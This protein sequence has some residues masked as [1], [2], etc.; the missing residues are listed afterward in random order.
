MDKYTPLTNDIEAFKE[1]N[2]ELSLKIQFFDEL[3]EHSHALHY[4][5]DLKKDK[6]CYV[7]ENVTFFLGYTP[8]EIYQRSFKQLL[9]EIHPDDLEVVDSQI[10]AASL[11][12]CKKKFHYVFEYRRKTKN[13]MYNWFQDWAT[14]VLDDGGNL[15]YILGSLY[16]I[17]ERKNR[18]EKLQKINRDLEKLLAERTKQYHNKSTQFEKDSVNW[19]KAAQRSNKTE[20][21]YKTAFDSIP[22]FIM[23]I[24]S[25]SLKILYYNSFTC[26]NTGFDK[27]HFINKNLNDI[28]AFADL[29]SKID[30]DTI[31]SD[32]FTR[33]TSAITNLKGMSTEYTFYITEEKSEKSLLIITGIEKGATIYNDMEKSELISTM[34]EMYESERERLSCALH[35][36]LAQLLAGANIRYEL[37]YN[38]NG[39]HDENSQALRDILQKSNKEIRKQLHLLQHLDVDK[40]G[41]SA[42]VDMYCNQLIKY[43]NVKIEYL[44]KN[45]NG[46]LKKA[47]EKHIGVLVQELLPCLIE[48]KLANDI[49]ITLVESQYELKIDIIDNGISP[50][51]LRKEDPHNTYFQNVMDTAK[52]RLSLFNGR[53]EQSFSDVTNLTTTSIVIII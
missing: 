14:L 31:S 22:A 13:G 12:R 52:Y 1:E 3:L 16:D 9:Q 41:L 32:G 33:F 30:Y 21:M 26:N 18:E 48:C 43:L 49:S 46:F 36:E 17:N 35:S 34:L 2:E 6:F 45:Y 51:S 15:S 42:S 53:I 23:I 39:H 50:D 25:F 10:A 8:N 7:S 44:D 4:R 28:G 40:Y 37:L 11:N 19:R 5:V 47:A 29:C 27:R 24:E 20:K 38:Q